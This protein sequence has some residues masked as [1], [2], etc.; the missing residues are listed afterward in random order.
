MSFPSVNPTQTPAWK[1]LAKHFSTIKKEKMQDYFINNPQRAEEF[2]LNWEDFYIDFSKNRITSETLTLLLQLAEQSQLKEAIEAMFTGQKIN[3]TENRAA[4]HTALRDPHQPPRGVKKTLGQMKRFS[5]E[6]LSGQW[7][8]YSGK[9]I[10]DVVN[11]GIG[12]SDLGPQM[13][14]QAL[15]YYKTHLQLHFISNIDGDHLREQLKKLNPETTLFI[16]VSK[17]FTTPETLTNA[18]TV[19]NWFLQKATVLDIEKHFVAV[20]GNIPAVTRFGIAKENIFPMWEWV[21]GR[22]SLW[23]A[24][25]LSICCA[26][27]Y[28]NFEKL[29]QGAH[30]MDQHFKTTAFA[31]NIPVV[32]ALLSIW[33]NNFFKSETE[34]IIPY[35]EYLSK[36][37]PYLQQASMESNG[38]NRDRNGKKIN[39]QTGQIVWGCT[40]TNAQHAFFQLL[41]QGTKLVPVQFIVFA[42]ALYENDIHQQTLL[43]NCFAQSEALLQGT[44]GKSVENPFQFFEGNRPSTTLLIKKLT[45]ENLG[46]LLAMY[47]HKIF[48]EGVVLNIFSYD[49]WGVELGKKLADHTLKAI[50]NKDVSIIGNSSSRQLI[51]KC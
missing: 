32:L 6:I 49:Q 27:G 19:R 23:S 10:T 2:S 29:L 45:P 24:V 5:K 38:K 21:G 42:E 41:H 46:A 14:C 37:V 26:I 12:G 9:S 33:Y 28:K 39:Y 13:V 1:T 30:A 35:S 11:I 36:L 18:E 4:W 7:K 17:S 47:E 3:Q 50:A 40:G 34:A 51:K 43:A 22:F 20:S 44:Y 15:H 48:V 8:G 16:V 25:G 31:K